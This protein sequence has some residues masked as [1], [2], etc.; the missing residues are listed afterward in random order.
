MADHMSAHIV[1]GG[2]LSKDKLDEFLGLISELH[3]DNFNGAPAEKKYIMLCS[4]QKKSL[5]LAD[6]Q[7][8]YGEFEALEKFCV[9]NNLCFKRQGSPKREYEGEIR[10]FSPKTCDF[11]FG[12][13]DNG[14]PY[15]NRSELEAYLKKGLTLQEV[16]D[17]INK[18]YSIVPAFEFTDESLDL[19]ELIANSNYWTCPECE[20]VN[21]EI[22]SNDYVT[23]RKCKK[24][25]QVVKYFCLQ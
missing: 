11:R 15:L 10:Y 18:C 9:I 7:A 19:I 4:E 17:T 8:R 16:I 23:C 24:R 14:D 21:E 2:K 13:T 5:F 25:Y 3:A 22:K 6:F 1:I 20:N 12:A